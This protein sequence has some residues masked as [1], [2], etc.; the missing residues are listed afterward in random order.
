[1]EEK[2][3]KIREIILKTAEK[4]GIEVER[5]ILFGSRARRDYSEGRDWDILVVT[6]NKLERKLEDKFWL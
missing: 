6:G 1:M 3:K 5:I 2:L 4:Y